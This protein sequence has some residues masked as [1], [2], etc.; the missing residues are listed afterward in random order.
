MLLAASCSYNCDGSVTLTPSGGDN[1]GFYTYTWTDQSTSS[2][3]AN[4]CPST[5]YCTITD[6]GQCQT[7]A[8]PFVI[9]APAAININD[10]TSADSNC[11][12]PYNGCIN[13]IVSGGDGTYTYSPWGSGGTGS[14]DCSLAPGN[15]GVTVT[16]GAGC[17][18]NS[19]ANVGFTGGI[20]VNLGPPDTT[21]CG[22]SVILN[23][24]NPGDLYSWTNHQ[25]T[26][27]ITVSSSNTYGVTVTDPNTGC[28]ASG[29]VNV[30]ILAAPTVN[31]G[32]NVVQCGGNATL[33]AGNPGD[34]YHWSDG[35]SNETL[36]VST[37]GTY[38]VTVTN[39]VACSA[40]GSIEVYIKPAPYVNLGNDTT[41]CGG[42]IT[43]NAGNPGDLYSWNDN[44]ST[45]IITVS[46]SLNYS[47]TVTDPNSGCMGSSSVNVTINPVPV[48]NLGSDSTQCGGSITVDAGNPGD[49][50]N[51]SNGTTGRSI[52]ITTS[53]QYT[54]TVTNS[55]NCSASDSINIYI[56]SV[57][58]VYLGQDITQCGGSVTLDAGNPNYI[59]LWST[60]QTA[61]TIQVSISGIYSVTVTSP[62]DG[63]PASDTINVTIDT[64]PVV[65]LGPA[66]TQCGGSVTLDAGNA[67]STYL[68]SD[69]S[70]NE[71]LVVTTSGIY[72]VTVTNN[73]TGCTATGSVSVTINPIPTV[74]V[75][76]PANVCITVPSFALTGGL[77]AGG[78][79]FEADTAITIFNPFQQGIGAHEITYVYTNTYGCADSDSA[80][81]FVHPQ[82]FISTVSPPYLCIP[83]PKLTSII[84]S[85]HRAA[86]ILALALARI[87]STLI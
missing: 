81:I 64:I 49:T 43:L 51:W 72:R 6:G 85:R 59:Y 62:V 63:C 27:T 74:T 65:N 5:V 31:L 10:F 30:T 73:G 37:S 56:L 9:S 79:Y 20:S 54:V 61:Q 1:S 41:Q 33:D 46:S 70:T 11:T 71:T 26:Q 4:L 3:D 52:Y 47:V 39:D 15:Y 82:P 78:T 76:L 21:Q 84:I 8:G 2:Q 40:S 24:G 36:I 16:D 23:A 19:S 22:G 18:A 38:L 28:T 45:Q 48:V 83:L 58:T 87:I 57:P 14:S 66:I 55:F 32:P 50:Y 25:T 17:T 80:S 34:F 53:G 75:T 44:E 12:A 69:N 86:G 60:N 29:S 68:W 35:S 42:S 7:V 77:P 13:W 67:G